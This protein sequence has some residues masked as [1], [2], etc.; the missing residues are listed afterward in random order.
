MCLPFFAC[1]KKDFSVEPEKK[2][3]D[4]SIEK[5]FAVTPATPK[6]VQGVMHDLK[7]NKKFINDLSAFV[8]KNGIPVWDKTKFI[9]RS[10]PNVSASSKGTSLSVGTTEKGFYLIPLQSTTCPDIKSYVACKQDADSLYAYSL[11]NKDSVSHLT[12]TSDSAKRNLLNTLAVFGYFEKSVNNIDS[13]S[14]NG[15]LKGNI[16]GANVEFKASGRASTGGKINIHTTGFHSVLESAIYLCDISITIDITYYFEEY[17]T[18]WSYAPQ[19]EFIAMDV[20]ITVDIFCVDLGGGG[21][22]SGGGSGGFGGPG[23]VSNPYSP[24]YDPS[25]PYYNPYADPTN[26]NYDP[27]R[28]P[29]SPYYNPANDPNN[30]AIYPTGYPSGPNFNPNLFPF[31]NGGGGGTGA[32]PRTTSVTIDETDAEPEDP[33]NLADSIYIDDN[34]I[35]N[36]L[37]YPPQSRPTWANVFN[38][39]PKVNNV[40]ELDAH[41]VYAQIGGPLGANAAASPRQYANACA[42]RVSLALNKAGINI[43]DIPGQTQKGADGKNYFIKAKHLYSFLRKTFGPPDAKYEITDP[44]TSISKFQN[45]IL[46]KKGIYIMIPVDDTPTGF[47]ATGHASLW[48]GIDCMSNHNYMYGKGGVKRLV[49]WELK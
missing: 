19:Y 24:D 34:W 45:D 49:F 41:S 38:N 28:D 10:K 47:N 40:T 12:P 42:A 21:G 17:T 32:P 11:Y 3:P 35:D 6:E 23:D 43:P 37:S 1:R 33:G 18:S 29:N 26:W 48:L 2:A 27:S 36:N 9:T 14:V 4:I 5:F 30:W 13:V 15:A 44:N 16:K 8:A 7:K 22:G 46:L 39:Y 25:S 20:T 31:W